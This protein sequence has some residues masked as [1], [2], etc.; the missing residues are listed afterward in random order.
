[1]EKRV[2]EFTAFRVE[3]QVFFSHRK[4]DKWINKMVF[5]KRSTNRIK[6]KKLFLQVAYLM[7]IRLMTCW[8]LEQINGGILPIFL[9][10]VVAFFLIFHLLDPCPWPCVFAVIQNNQNQFINQNPNGVGCH[11]CFFVDSIQFRVELSPH[12]SNLCSITIFN[13]SHI[14]EWRDESFEMLLTLVVLME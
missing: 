2:W 5:G 14:I 1:M 7:S 8:L 13:S 12:R 6:T 11:I 9:L 10:F 3:F 4:H